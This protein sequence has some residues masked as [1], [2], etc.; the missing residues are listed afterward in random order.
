M[1]IARC[2]C[3]AELRADALWVARLAR[4][5]DL[6]RRLHQFGQ[7]TGDNYRWSTK[8]MDF[9]D[10]TVRTVW[11]LRTRVGL[12]LQPLEPPNSMLRCCGGSPDERTKK[13]DTIP[14]FAPLLNIEFW[15]SRGE[16]VCALR[17]ADLS[18]T[19]LVVDSADASRP[20]FLSTTRLK[21]RLRLLSN[22]LSA[23]WF[24]GHNGR[25]PPTRELVVNRNL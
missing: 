3:R 7:N 12:E 11:D 9:F 6:P 13:M 2:R 8:I 19:K 10:V 16:A 24:F 18:A 17:S 22:G 21:Y 5:H 4:P 25:E 23:S 20:L 1:P 15:G 14:Y